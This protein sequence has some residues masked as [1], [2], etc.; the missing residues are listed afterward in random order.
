MKN[1]RKALAL[2]FVF[3]MVFSLAACNEGQKDRELN[4]P[5]SGTPVDES[6]N[7]VAIDPISNEVVPDPDGSIQ[8]SNEEKNDEAVNPDAEKPVTEDPIATSEDVELF[9]LD[10]A[11]GSSYVVNFYGVKADGYELTE[12]GGIQSGDGKLI[13]TS[14]NVSEFKPI[15]RLAFDKQT[16]NLELKAQD[17]V[18]GGNEY[19][20]RINQYVTNITVKLNVQPSDVTNGI[21]LVRPSDTSMAEIRAN[22]NKAIL[23]EGLFDLEDGE[24]AIVAT[25]PTQPI[26]LVVSLK[27]LGNVKIFAEAYAGSAMT[28]CLIS[29]VEGKVTPTPAP[30]EPPTERLNASDDIY[31]HYHTHNYVPT[32]VAPTVFEQG[33]TIYTCSDCGHSYID[34][35]TAKLP[36]PEPEAT[37]HIHDYTATIVAPTETEQGYTLHS[38]I[39]GDSYKDSFIPALQPIGG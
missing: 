10:N 30:T 20:T 34:N 4:Y 17:D 33:Y 31:A 15:K 29:S 37:P 18:V 7:P 5:T 13:V 32:V 9:R 25:D 1:V 3:A 22:N 27:K 2:I 19:V 24:V 6:G 38:C 14:K 12:N 16:Y 26:N 8:A 39:C 35:Y 36:A 28:E 21:I 11:D 23:A